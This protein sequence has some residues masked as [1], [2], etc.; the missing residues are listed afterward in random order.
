[1]YTKIILIFSLIL[2]FNFVSA[3]YNS[4]DN[5]SI[6]RA[7]MCLYNWYTAQKAFYEEYSYYATS[8]KDLGVT[9]CSKFRMQLEL[10][11]DH[12]VFILSNKKSGKRIGFI[13]DYKEIY[14]Y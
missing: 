5:D 9:N 10:N 14:L 8:I 2:S 7:K 1:M 12:F 3:E 11:S 6:E 4:E 13:N